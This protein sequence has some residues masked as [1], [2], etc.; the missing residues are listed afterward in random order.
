MVAIVEPLFDARRRRSSA[1]RWRRRRRKAPRSSGT[2]I[3]RT[4]RTGVAE[5]LHRQVQRHVAA[6]HEVGVTAMTPSR[7]SRSR[8]VDR[9]LQRRHRP[10]AAE[11]G[12]HEP[13]SRGWRPH[14]EG[15]QGPGQPLVQHPLRHIAYRYYEALERRRHPCQLERPRQA[16]NY[17]P[18]RL[19]RPPR[20]EDRLRRHL[21][22]PSG[23]RLVRQLRAPVSS[24]S[25][26]CTPTSSPTTRDVVQPVA[27]RE[28]PI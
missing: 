5:V 12:L 23:A 11:R 8:G 3:S 7:S 10:Q 25:R 6:R 24:T 15:T 17:K 19:R 16:R 28:I 2:T 9:L 18:G 27:A 1:P 4:T 13:Y 14:P 21:H 26:S 22:R 20:A